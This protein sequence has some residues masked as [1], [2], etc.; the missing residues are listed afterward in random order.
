MSNRIGAIALLVV[1]LLG[2]CKA[3]ARPYISF[4]VDVTEQ[5]TYAIVERSVEV[6]I[7][8]L[9]QEGQPAEW[10]SEGVTSVGTKVIT[11]T[12][13]FVLP[14]HMGPGVVE[15][16]M[17]LAVS[18]A[19]QGDE[20]HCWVEVNGVTVKTSERSFAASTPPVLFGS[21]RYHLGDV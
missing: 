12:T 14:T 17:T 8:A 21:C 1:G 15:M 11:T 18:D 5:A 7:T 16:V 9:D 3:E 13:P 6:T 20:L 10:E 2:G 4:H 19:E